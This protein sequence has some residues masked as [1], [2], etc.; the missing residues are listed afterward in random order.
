MNITF[1][2]TTVL[3]TPKNKKAKVVAEDHPK[4]SSGL[5]PEQKDNVAGKRKEA[6]AN[7]ESNAPEGF[8]ESWATALAPEFEKDYFKKV[9]L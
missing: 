3:Q 5:S 9:G 2:C 8:G 1:C 7:L 4:S 6:M